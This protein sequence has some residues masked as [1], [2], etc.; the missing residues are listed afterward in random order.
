MH[1]DIILLGD[2]VDRARA[3]EVVDLTGI[4]CHGFETRLNIKHS[5]PVFA[6]II[7]ANYIKPL[8]ESELGM[9][10]DEDKQEIRAM[11]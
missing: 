5:F 7:E 2:L 1:K 6:T 11:A 4:Y 10:T 3:G 8:R 9:L